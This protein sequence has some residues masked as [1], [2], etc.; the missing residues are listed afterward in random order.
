MGLENRIKELQNPNASRSVQLVNPYS[1]QAQAQRPSYENPPPEIQRI[2]LNAVLTQSFNI[3]F[4]LN[5]SRF[6]EAVMS[7]SS[8]GHPERPTE[9]LLTVVNLLGLHLSRPQDA[10]IQPLLNSSLQQVSNMLNSTHPSRI[11]HGIQAEV[12][13]STYFFDTGRVVE[14]QYHLD[15]AVSL[16]IG[17]GLHQIRSGRTRR[18]ATSLPPP[19]DAIEEGERINA[20]WTVY[21]LSAVWG[22]ALGS[23]ESTSV[24]EGNGGTVDTPWPLD[25]VDYEKHGIPRGLIGTSTVQNF[26]SQGQSGNDRVSSVNALSA[27]ASVLLHSAGDLTTRFRSDISGS[28]RRRLLETFSSLDNL[29]DSFI[30]S[31]L[32][33]MDGLDPTSRVFG[34][35]LL[36]HTLAYAACIQLHSPFVDRDPSSMA[37]S[38]A[39]AEASVALLRRASSASFVSPIMAM[40][41]VSA[42]RV[43]LKELARLRRSRR[44][45][46]GNERE[47]ELLRELERLIEAM[48]VFAERSVLM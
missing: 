28:E 18:S 16:A 19:R 11:I 41:W 25:M 42:G 13:L 37:K 20:F 3:G 31:R 4:F 22:V 24:F 17:V 34:A 48:M 23:A 39:A 29:I 38:L 43:I 30:D 32:P 35:A 6:W 26:L 8:S 10:Q 9:G 12:L 33:P 45:A 40:L 21:M 15:A 5:P 36:S 2:L 14:G 27:Q 44:G 1:G 47:G 7:D 46:G